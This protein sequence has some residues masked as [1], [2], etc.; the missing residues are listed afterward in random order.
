M[1]F[2][3]ATV[4]NDTSFDA[5]FCGAI[6]IAFGAEQAAFMAGDCGSDEELLIS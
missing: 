6:E 3:Q 2:V 1:I 4:R 5:N